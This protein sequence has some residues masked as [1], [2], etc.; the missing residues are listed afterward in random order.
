L[1]GSSVSI[2]TIINSWAYLENGFLQFFMP[3]PDHVCVSHVNKVVMP[4]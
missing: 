4:P 2:T 1:H 3:I